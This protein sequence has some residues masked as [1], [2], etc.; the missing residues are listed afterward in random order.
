MRDEPEFNLVYEDDK[1]FY[2]MFKELIASNEKDILEYRKIN[3]RKNSIINSLYGFIIG[4]AYGV[5]YE[6]NDRS[7]MKMINN[8]EM[9][10]FGT[11]NKPAGTWSD[12]T[13][14][15]LA[16]ID[17]INDKK[18]IDYEDIMVKFCAWLLKNKFTTDGKVFDVGLTTNKAIKL[19]VNTSLDAVQ[20]GGSSIRDNGNG[21]LMRMMP[22]C[23]YL[24]KANLSEE[25]E[26]EIINNVSSLTHAHEISKLGCFIYYQYIKNLLNGMSKNDAYEAMCNYDYS[27]FYSLDSI[28]CYN[29][30]LS[31]NIKNESID[32][33]KSGGYI[34]DT[35][36]SVFYTILNNNNY[37]DSIIESVNLGGDT[38]TIGAITGSIA[39]I[40]YG[41][42]NI[43]KEWLD[44]IP[45]QD[46][47]NNLISTFDE[48]I[49][50]DNIKESEERITR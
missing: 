12:D 15:T 49:L 47:L 33:I 26:S 6:F 31:H 29:N 48:D 36:E 18:N 44:K 10:G 27:K 28:E 1:E 34:V 14:M 23:F 8:G 41:Y 40:L 11:H 16:T 9:N 38:D 43:P 30:L 13:A 42:E 24:S 32:N 4:D 21:S 37:K 5:P 45:K 35:L 25:E 17:S 19:Y 46:Y 39:G 2:E 20:C 7:K 3:N 50:K 22:V